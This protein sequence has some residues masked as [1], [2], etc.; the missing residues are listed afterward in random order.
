MALTQSS[1]LQSFKARYK[2]IPK[3]VRAIIIVLLSLLLLLVI[4]WFVLA[5]YISSHKQELL[6]RITAGVSENVD[7]NFHINDM[8]PAM[9]KG[10]PNISVRLEGVTLSDSMYS[11]HKK[12][13]IELQSVYIKLNVLSLLTKHP[14]VM[15]VTIAD[16]AVYLF[17]DKNGYSNTYLLKKKNPQKKPGQGKQVEI[18]KFGIEN[19]TFT[20][21][22][23]E[24]NKQFK[25]TFRDM[26]GNIRNNGDVMDI[27]AE[28]D[29][30]IHQLGFNLARGGFVKNKDLDANLHILF[31]RKTKDLQLPKQTVAMNGTDIKVGCIFHFGNKPA[32]YTIDIDAPSIGFR[33]STSFL[34]RHIAKKLD[35]FDLE[36]N[37]A[38][39]VTVNGSFKYPDTP[40]IY[41]R[42]QASDNVL[43]SSFGKMEHTD[44]KGSFYNNYVAGSG[45]GDDNSAVTITGLSASFSGIKFK[46]DSIVVYGLINPLMKL[47]LASQFPVEKLSAVV[48]NTFSFKGGQADV[49]LDYTGPILSSDTFR[50]SMYG[51]IRLKD[52]ALTYVPRNLSFQKCDVNLEFL[53]ND[54]VLHNT[55]L[56]S[57]NSSIKID[58]T[59][60]NFMNV[61]FLDPGRVNFDWNI[62]SKLIDL[63]EFKSFLA[64]RRKNAPPRKKQNHKIAKIADRLQLLLEKS[65]MFLH[66]NVNRLTYRHFDAQNIK[67]DIDLTQDAIQL[68]NVGL[69]HAGGTLTVNGVINQQNAGN[70]FQLKAKINSVE[71]NKLFYAFENFGIGALSS[72]NLQGS[73]SADIDIS[74]G[75]QESG[76]IIKNSMNGKVSFLLTNGALVN[77]APLMSIQKYAFKKRNLSNIT[78]KTLKNDLAISKGKINISPMEIESS[79]IRMKVQGVYAFDKGTDISLEIP[80]RNP[81]KD[82]ELIAQ[83]LEPKKKK[84]IIIYLR[85]MDGD[86]GKVKITW[87]PF[88]KGVKDEKDEPMFSEEEEAQ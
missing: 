58:G 55:T 36:R 31:N 72:N 57:R 76:A 33:E 87:D 10:F 1:R 3:W 25:V 12:N 45:L 42:W 28:T 85:A 78:F 56:S 19:V 77:F 65:S 79:A 48:D 40:L 17:T 83:G 54:L 11:S 14:E 81:K 16:G 67:A 51:H 7:G 46:A 75:L 82:E 39:Q 37:F 84:G 86:D 27:M 23:L 62:S 71:V 21:D 20:F 26:N 35:S 60:R 29:A 53:G 64:P 59:A 22:H 13:M 32:N 63:N 52:V 73:L 34:S 66:V 6:S 24:R 18:N 88:K 47:K 74:G 8:E 69:Q 41:A 44:L 68:R 80:L 4:A 70:P 49:K 15:K 9:L 61:Y 5:W 30:H 38:V 2:R 43:T 50:H